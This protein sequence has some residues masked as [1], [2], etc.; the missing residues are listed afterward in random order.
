[1][2]VWQE[3]IGGAEQGE[4]GVVQESEATN[5][6]S[7]LSCNSSWLAGWLAAH[8]AAPPPLMQLGVLVCLPMHHHTH[9]RAQGGGKRKGAFAIYI[10]PWH[11]DIFEWLD[12]RK[13]HGKEEARAR[14]LFYGLW[15]NDLFMQV[16]VCGGVVA[17]WVG[18]WVVEAGAARETDRGPSSVPCIICTHACIRG[19]VLGFLLP[20]QDTVLIAVFPAFLL[21]LLGCLCH[22]AR[23][24]QRGLEPLLP[25]RGPRPRGSVGRG[26]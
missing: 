5:T 4:L 16:C 7:L 9:A 23:G 3:H 12:L 24:G 2:H 15:I 17:E 11:A 26:L 18:G 13:N 22:T 10:E 6:S 19:A 1:M 14:D 8:V 25:Q 21:L 20:Q